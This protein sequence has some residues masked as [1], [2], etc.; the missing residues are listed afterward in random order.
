MLQKVVH[1]AGLLKLSCWA[2]FLSIGH[3]CSHPYL[4]WAQLGVISA[5]LFY[6]TWT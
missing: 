2:L 4:F 1:I 3:S 5:S 6:L